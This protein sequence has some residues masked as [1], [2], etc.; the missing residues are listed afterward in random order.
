MGGKYDGLFPKSNLEA[1]NKQIKG[2][3]LEFFEGGHMFLRQ[4]PNAFSK[5]ISFLNK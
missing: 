2:S 5:V 1:L 3:L 4:D